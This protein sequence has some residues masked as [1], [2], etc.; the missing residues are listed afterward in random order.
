MRPSAFSI[1][2]EKSKTVESANPESGNREVVVDPEK[3]ILESLFF[4]PIFTIE[5]SRCI[6]RKSKT[7][8]KGERLRGMHRIPDLL[9]HHV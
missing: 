4:E 7:P 5:K 8:D 3:L 1:W 9:I 6:S 2:L